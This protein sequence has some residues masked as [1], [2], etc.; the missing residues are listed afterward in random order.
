[1]FLHQYDTPSYKMAIRLKASKRGCSL[2][3]FYVQLAQEAVMAYRS[4]SSV[5]LVL[6]FDREQVGGDTFS[7]EHM[8]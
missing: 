1:M 6:G 7:S 3:V 8:K 2:R 4:D 5:S